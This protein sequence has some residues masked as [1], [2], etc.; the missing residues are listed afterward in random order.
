MLE[1]HSQTI[2]S[3]YVEL[4]PILLMPALWERPGYIPALVR[5]LQVYIEKGAT[6]V[7]PEKIVSS[8]NLNINIELKFLNWQSYS[9][10]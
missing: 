8:F 6:T 4:F 1:L 7:I 5:L 9:A 2:P 3:V 10:G